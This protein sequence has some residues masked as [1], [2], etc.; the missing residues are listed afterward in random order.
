MSSTGFVER[1]QRRQGGR[2]VDLRVVVEIVAQREVL[3][4]IRRQLRDT[5]VVFSQGQEIQIALA[6]TNPEATIEVVVPRLRK[7]LPGQC[8][9][10]VNG[11][12]IAA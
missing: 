8:A 2:I 5:D 4:L 9:F 6:E 10:L 1:D 12:A 11:Q 7:T 3:D